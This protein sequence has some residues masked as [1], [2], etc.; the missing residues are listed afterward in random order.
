MKVEPL[1]WLLERIEEGHN[2][3][4]LLRKQKKSATVLTYIAYSLEKD[5]IDIEGEDIGAR[6][7]KIYRLTEKGKQLLGILKEGEKI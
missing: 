3:L 1:L 2:T 6:K 7:K 5:L 4:Y